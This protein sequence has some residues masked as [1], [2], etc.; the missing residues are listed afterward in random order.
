MPASKRRKK[1]GRP[2]KYPMPE[3]TADR[4]ENIMRAILNTPSKPRHEWRY[5]KESGREKASGV[6]RRIESLVVN[7]TCL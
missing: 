7:W 2:A 6:R 5:M 1:R 4:E 3:S